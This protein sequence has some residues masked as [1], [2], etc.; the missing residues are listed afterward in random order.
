MPYKNRFG[1]ITAD[2]DVVR[3]LIFKRGGQRGMQEFTE[4]FGT[5]PQAMRLLE[6]G[7]QDM[8]AKAVVRDGQ[9][10]PNLVETFMRDHP[11]LD[12]MPAL[13]ARLTNIDR[14][15]DLL[16]QRQKTIIEQRKMLDQTELARIAKTDNPTE[17]V[18]NA[19]T[20]RK[21]MLA[22]TSQ[23]KTVEE[24]QILAR[25]IAEAV[26][27]QPNPYEFLMNNAPNL[28]RELEK[29]GPGHFD[30]LLNLAKAAQITGR[31]RAPS[32]VPLERLQDIGEQ[33]AGTSI[34]GLLSRGMNVAKGYMSPEYAA[35]DIGG[36]YIFKIK[37]AEADRLM[38]EAIYDPAA[39]KSL[40]E[41]VRTPNEQKWNSL[42]NHMFSHGIK[43]VSVAKTEE[44]K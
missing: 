6:N 29:L 19:L 28:R 38:Q 41:M 2:E 22:L 1:E 26:S 13:K 8:F 37:S 24:K 7:V 4:L 25:S 14:A 39:A 40:M 17:M 15:N 10:K 42:R 30:N 9:I 20:D 23:A 33:T 34:K 5:D 27:R 3:N 21:S 18:Q 11:Q 36:R 32:H 12:Q 16:L 44:N 31:T 43:V 35:F